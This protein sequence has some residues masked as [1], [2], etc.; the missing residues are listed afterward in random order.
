MTFQDAA[1]ESA[2]LYYKYLDEHGGGQIEYHVTG[3]V[4][5]ESAFKKNEYW[6]QLDKKPKNTD[7]LIVRIQNYV[8]ST[9][10]IK[11]VV[12]NSHTRML[13]VSLSDSTKGVFERYRPKDIIVFSDLKFLVRR[14][15]AW[16]RRFGDRLA[17]PEGNQAVEPA[18][19]H[20][21]SKDPS[22]DQERAIQ[23][24]L[25][26]PFTYVWGAPGTGKTQF[27]LARSVLA[28]IQAGKRVL[29][30]APTNNAVE[31]SL[32]GLLP[33]LEEAGLDYNELVIRLGTANADFLSKYPGVC[34]DTGY[35]KAI[36]EILDQLSALQ[37]SKEET[38]KKEQ[39]FK[40]Y[41][42]FRQ[43]QAAYAEMTESLKK[44]ITRISEAGIRFADSQS[45][46]DE[47]LLSIS[48]KESESKECDNSR[49]FYNRQAQDLMQRLQN[50]F[51]AILHWFSKK[52]HS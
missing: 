43:K 33:V 42:A 37:I 22:E 16:Y 45:S 21:L 8:Y 3:I 47:I 50:P 49:D 19:C 38:A 31:Q 36:S 9:E 10:Q 27:V 11:P 7:S 40:E 2:Q 35:S 28:Y 5:E 29:V 14:V 32:N 25:T 30:T 46:V 6:L 51:Y 17:L 12:Y 26:E 23:G 20:M 34:E 39:L 41:Q 13:K 44:L 15:E 24:A 4:K 48:Q 18:D 1:V 52:I